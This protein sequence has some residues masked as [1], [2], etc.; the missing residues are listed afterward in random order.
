MS[1]VF[2]LFKQK[3]IENPSDPKTVVTN[4]VVN[5]LSSSAQLGRAVE[6]LSKRLDVVDHTI[7]ALGE[8]DSGTRFKQATKMSRKILTEVILEFSRKL[9]ALQQELAEAVT[10]RC[11]E[12]VNQDLRETVTTDSKRSEPVSMV[13]RLGRLSGP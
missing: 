2:Q 13:I 1:N 7:D 10:R 4:A 8:S 3:K 11:G 12:T 5:I 6:E 9:P